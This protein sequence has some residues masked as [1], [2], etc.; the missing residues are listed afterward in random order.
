V[1]DGDV[2]VGVVTRRDLLDVARAGDERI[3]ELVRRPPLVVQPDDSLRDA[4]DLMV[5]QDVGRLP[6]VDAAGRVIGIVTRSDLLAAHVPRLEE[7]F[8]VEPRAVAR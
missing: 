1:D 8:L 4:A 3:D 5:R 7:E 6:V 2:L